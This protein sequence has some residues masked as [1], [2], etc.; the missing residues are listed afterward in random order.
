MVILKSV[1]ARVC[2]CDMGKKGEG[3][4][5]D[6]FFFLNVTLFYIVKILSQIIFVCTH[7][8]QSIFFSQNS[9][10]DKKKFSKKTCTHPPLSG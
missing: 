2:V 8:S 4:A 10:S 3:L 1:C 9:T 5:D 6:I 7:P